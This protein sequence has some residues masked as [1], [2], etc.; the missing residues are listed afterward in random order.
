MTTPELPKTAKTRGVAR[1]GLRT[2]LFCVLLVAVYFAGW[3]SHRRAMRTKIEVLQWTHDAAVDIHESL[4][5]LR[6]KEQSSDVNT[7]SLAQQERA[8]LEKLLA[9]I[10]AKNQQ[11]LRDLKMDQLSKQAALGPSRLCLPKMRFHFEISPTH[12]RLKQ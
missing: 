6:Q 9:D 12:G 2:L 5:A 10:M 1:F 3:V 8:R 7:R 11:F 4:M